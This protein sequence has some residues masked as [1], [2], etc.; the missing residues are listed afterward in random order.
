MT[1]CQACV[2]MLASNWI[3]ASKFTLDAVA[4]KRFSNK[5]RCESAF[6]VGDE[7]FHGTKEANPIL[8]KATEIGVARFVLETTNL[9]VP[10]VFVNEYQPYFVPNKE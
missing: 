3:R 8:N 6:L 1:F 2:G 10:D 9:L 5:I 4:V 7:D